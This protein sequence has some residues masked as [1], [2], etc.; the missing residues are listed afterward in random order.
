MST[1]DRGMFHRGLIP[2]ANQADRAKKYVT[3]VSR[4][5]A[6]PVFVGCHWFQ[7][8]DQP[9]TGRSY[10]GENFNIGLVNVCDIPYHELT[11]AAR[12]IHSRLYP[13]RYGAGE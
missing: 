5:A 4:V 1:L 10:G 2:A 6:N 9:T 12:A 13:M 7:Y 11:S 8:M 3:Y